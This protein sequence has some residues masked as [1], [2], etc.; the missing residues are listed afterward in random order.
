MTWSLVQITY[1]V[2]ESLLYSTGAEGWQVE[3]PF[4]SKQHDT[5][6]SASSWSEASKPKEWKVEINEVGGFPN[7]SMSQL[8]IG[9]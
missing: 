7:A 1:T 5:D 3:V 4:W 6:N 8:R 2:Q 9:G